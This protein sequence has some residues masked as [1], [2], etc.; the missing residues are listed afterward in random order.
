MREENL[1]S[2]LPLLLRRRHF[3]GLKFPPTEVWDSVDDD[4][5]ECTTKVNKLAWGNNDEIKNGDIHDGT[6][7]VKQKAHQT[8]RNDRVVK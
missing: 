5:W 8:S 1:L 3:A 7:L 6:H 2:T 4:P